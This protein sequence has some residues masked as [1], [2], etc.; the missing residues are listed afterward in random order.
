M[1][2]ELKRVLILMIAA[3]CSIG[4]FA[5]SIHLEVENP[6][7]RRSIGVGDTFWISICIKD[8]D[9]HLSQ[10]V[11][12]P[13]C[14][15]VYFS[16]TAHSS[17][18]T[19]VNGKS[20]YSS[21]TIYTMTLKARKEGSYSFGP[22][23]V[24]NVK[25]NSVKFSIG[26]AGSNSPSGTAQQGGA[27][28]SAQNGNGNPVYIGKGDDKLFLRASVS[29]TTAYEQEALVYTIKLYSSYAGVKFVGATSAPVFDGFVI[30]ESKIN[31]MQLDYETYNGKTYATAVIARYIIF[32][33][34]AGDLKVLGNTYTVSVN[35]QE[36]Y[37][38]PYFGQLAVNR[39]VQLNVK[40]NDLAVNVKAL[41]TPRPAN[42]SGGVGKFSM[43]SEIRSTELRTNQA[44]SVIYKVAGAGNLKYV[45]LPDLNTMYPAQLE[46][47][48][49]TTEVNSSVQGGNTSGTVIF[50][51][52]FMPLETGQFKIPSVDLVYFNPETGKYETS[53]AKGYTIDVSK[54]EVS[55]K[56]QTKDRLIF[57]KKLQ[58]VNEKDTNISLMA[59]SWIYSLWYI[60]PLLLLVLTFFFYRKHLKELSDLS[61]LKSKKAN[62][63]AK[64]RLRKAE[65]CLKLNKSD[66]FYDEMLSA[67]WGYISD[68]LGI[69]NS[70]LN[71][72]NIRQQLLEKGVSDDVLMQ[73]INLIDECEFAKYSSQSGQNDMSTI[74]NHGCEVIDKLENTIKKR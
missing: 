74:Y 16:Q 51:Y 46:V 23:S 24:G 8:M 27:N 34:M 5:A 56:S 38:D 57:H 50:D 58:P 53:S 4:L 9:G 2:K 71:R 13:G 39:P 68:K 3:V 41:P 43:S 63:V 36:Y 1:R 15:I 20:S 70:D 14:D 60:I 44:A 25:S 17:S 59:D 67:V 52:S 54:G 31:T 72:D 64:K 29:K 22:V 45:K 47:Y 21:Q 37:A 65:S 33:Q 26:A 40:P 69:P 42:F 7:G 61:L 35:S 48:S 32:P 18:S 30:E 49:P 6:R 73:V 12:V 11:N 28:S 55:A 10:P 66:N 62:K 19:W